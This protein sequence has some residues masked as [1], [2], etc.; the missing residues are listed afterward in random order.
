MARRSDRPAI[1]APTK[2]NREGATCLQEQ[3]VQIHL[4]TFARDSADYAEVRAAWEP[5]ILEQEQLRIATGAP[6]S[7]LHQIAYNGFAKRL[8]STS[9]MASR[10][11]RNIG[12][13]Q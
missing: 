4:L 3:A 2:Q 13:Q 11:R 8:P 7:N 1:V 9:R 12:S 10:C 6:T 5:L